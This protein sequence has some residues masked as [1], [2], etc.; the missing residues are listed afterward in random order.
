[1]TDLAVIDRQLERS[2][3]DALNAVQ[4]A[5]DNA[6]NAD[7]ALDVKAK[8]EAAKA[9]ARTH[10]LI[11]QWRAELLA[12]EVAALVRV[13][14]LGGDHLLT[15][16]EA[17]AAQW[18]RDMPADDLND[19]IET[20]Q[21]VTTAVGLWRSHLHAERCATECQD[22][23]DWADNPT[24]STREPFYDRG[25]AARAAREAITSLIEEHV[26]D[27]APFTVAEV[28]DEIMSGLDNGVEPF[29]DGVR[30]MTRQALKKMPIGATLDGTMIPRTITAVRPDG[31]YVRIPTLNALVS[32]LDQAAAIKQ[33]GIDQDIAAL[34][35]YQSFVDRVKAISGAAPASKVGDP[36]AST[37]TLD[38]A[39]AVAA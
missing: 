34:A 39:E 27:G 18:F 5:L 13:S 14:E 2:T 37:L 38:K 23:R 15:G 35:K 29:A 30:D 31:H 9:W 25:A 12:A 26:E 21:Q 8:L 7:E 22:G 10:K 1:M 28:A 19:W 3:R 36:I 11:K 4:A 32:Q 33:E 20:H 6:T 24:E 17:E 16:R